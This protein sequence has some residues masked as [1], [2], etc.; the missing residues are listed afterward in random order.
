MFNI[1]TFFVLLELFFF[2]LLV[3]RSQ[4]HVLKEFEGFGPIV[5]P[6]FIVSTVHRFILF[7]FYTIK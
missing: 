1:N 3:T 2:V 4:L 7:V 5:I 6:E